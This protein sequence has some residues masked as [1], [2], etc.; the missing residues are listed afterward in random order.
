MVVAQINR[1]GHAMTLNA[2]QQI[3]AD[4]LKPLI[5]QARNEGKWLWCRYQGLW[6][7]P[8]Y[9]EAQNA[10]GAFLWG[11]GNWKVRDPQERLEDA[12]K[13]LT[14]AQDNVDRIAAEIGTTG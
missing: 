4:A 2:Q 12:K 5:E 11:P 7:S 14:A 13:A 6:F 9:L 8:D 10:E 3:I 1:M